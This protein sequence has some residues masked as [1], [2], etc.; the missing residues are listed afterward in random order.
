[1]KE[2]MYMNPKRLQ[3][4]KG[5]NSKKHCCKEVS[6]DNTAKWNEMTTFHNHNTELTTDYVVKNQVEVVMRNI[7][8][9][10]TTRDLTWF[11]TPGYNKSFTQNSCLTLW[12]TLDMALKLNRIKLFIMLSPISFIWMN[13]S[14]CFHT[15]STQSLSL[16]EAFSNDINM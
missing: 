9:A 16:T 15:T 2:T 11:H 4:H 1:M 13:W 10:L 12:P 8:T 6:V 7:F 5:C 14:L 3:S